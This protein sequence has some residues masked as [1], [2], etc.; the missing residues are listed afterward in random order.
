MGYLHTDNKMN[1]RT[2]RLKAISAQRILQ[3]SAVKSG[4]DDHVS[5]APVADRGGS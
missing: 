1:D 2:H 4:G 5:Y 3:E